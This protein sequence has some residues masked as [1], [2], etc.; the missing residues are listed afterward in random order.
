MR[1]LVTGA[2]GFVGRHLIPALIERNFSVVAAV[3][4]GVNCLTPH[5]KLSQ[6]VVGDLESTNRLDA[7]LRDVDAVVHL[8]ARVHVMKDTHADAAAKY[9]RANVE[10]T[11]RLAQ[12]AA[13]AGC[14]HFVYLSSIKVNGERT[15]AAAFTP[16]DA[17]NP[18][19][20]YARSKLRAEEALQNANLRGRMRIAI[21]RPPL[22]YGPWVG[23]NY[24]RML[25][26][27]ARGVWLPFGAVENRRSLLSV[28]NLC[29]FLGHVLATGFD[30]P[31]PALIS[32]GPAIS[33]PQ[34]LSDLARALG[35]RVR[36][37]RVPHGALIA[38]ATLLGMQSEIKRLCESLVIDAD[39]TMQ[40]AHW[41]PPV[42]PA[43]A[44][45]ATAAWFRTQ[46]G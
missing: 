9:Q 28:L 24:L 3:R 29:D 8:A 13:S 10:V 23:G 26:L 5:P 41:R 25:R 7:P 35:V 15:A 16:G 11:K 20:E 22:V 18:E 19:D 40:K 45:Q 2:G 14:R 32:D 6:L 38:G 39:A 4:E 43:E 27:V 12:A 31:E 36:L 21:V 33:T 34:L 30:G 44:I 37:L 42:S 46:Y 1:V 17:P